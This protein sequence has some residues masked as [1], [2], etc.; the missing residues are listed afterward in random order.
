MKTLKLLMIGL[1]LLCAHT[2]NAQKKTGGLKGTVYD[3]ET[4]ETLP[5]TNVVLKD[6]QGMIVAGGASD[7]DGTFNINPLAPKRYTIEA[8]FTGYGKE[9][10]N[11]IEISAGEHYTLDVFLSMATEELT[12]CIVTYRPACF[13]SC[14]LGCYPRSCTGGVISCYAYSE[15]LSE[16]ETLISDFEMYPNPSSGELNLSTDHKIDQV[17]ITNISGQE[18]AEIDVTDLSNIKANLEHLPPATYVVHFFDGKSRNSKLW[19]LRP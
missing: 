16:E 12:E 5:F 7:I 17:F 11:E 13:R 18:V 6:D 10:F 3:I 1:A 15:A 14:P 2:A 19:I 9:V 8:S 4:M